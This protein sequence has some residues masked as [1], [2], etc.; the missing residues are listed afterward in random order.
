MKKREIEILPSPATIVRAT[1]GTDKAQLEA[2]V[3]QQVAEIMAERDALVF[4]PFFRSRKVAYELKRLQ[5]VPEQKKFSIS[6]ERYGCMIC[7]TR[8]RPHI[9]NGM[10]GNCHARWFRRLSQIIAE[11]VSGEPAHA[12]KGARGLERLLP[13]NATPGVHHTWY[14]P[15]TEDEQLIYARVAE[16]LRVGVQWVAKVAGGRERS[17]SRFVS[18]VLNEERAAF[19]AER[20][21][22]ERQRTFA[23]LRARMADD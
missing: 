15:T 8:D 3:R 2:M 18:E 16:R 9:S 20:A 10:C 19:E 7:E 17:R 21:Q 1:S 6:Y 5:T 14:K 4:E 13:E 23:E 11:E 12:A 22:M